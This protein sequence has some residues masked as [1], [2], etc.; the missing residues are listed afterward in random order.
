MP[1]LKE[2]TLYQGDTQDP[3]LVGLKAVT[4]LA[5]YECNLAVVGTAIAREVVTIS[6]RYF[7]VQLTP[8]ETATLSAGQT[9]K[10]GVQISNDALTPVFVKELHFSIKVE[11]QAVTA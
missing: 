2:F 4:D 5:G 7:V 6:G 11:E 10:L 9:Y 1:V 3:L 8:A